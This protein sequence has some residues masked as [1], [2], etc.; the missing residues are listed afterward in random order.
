M[1][2]NVQLKNIITLESE[3]GPF[4]SLFISLD[5]DNNFSEILD[6][7][8]Q[9]F[10]KKYPN[11]NWDQYQN[12][13]NERA[14][15][16]AM[17][18]S[19]CQS[20]AIYIGPNIFH[21]FKL[22]HY[23]VKTYYLIDNTMQIIPVIAESQFKSLNHLAKLKQKAINNIKFHYQA[24]MK[25]KRASNDINEIMHAATAGRIDALMLNKNVYDQNDPKI[26]GIMNDLAI[27]TA[28]FG[29]NVFVLKNE[30]MPVND[31]KIAMILRM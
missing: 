13:L 17:R 16:R 15:R 24:S 14:V 31:T 9:D 28:G 4:I 11:S 30:E 21:I 19:R 2:S 10:S 27:T 26:N 25:F 23:P 1:T 12:Q 6:H 20:L 18:A 8:K 5:T 3:S 29:G 7:I 22:R